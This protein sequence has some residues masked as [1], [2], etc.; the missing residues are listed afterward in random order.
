MCHK[1]AIK[2]RKT[3]TNLPKCENN[4]KNSMFF[5]DVVVHQ[6]SFLT[7]LF[8]LFG[9]P[10]T[11]GRVLYCIGFVSRSVHPSVY[12]SVRLDILELDHQFC[13]NFCIVVETYMKFCVAEPDFQVVFSPQKQG[14]WIK[15]GREIGS[16][17]FIEKFCH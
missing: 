12:L 1:G 5:M 10:T 14:K 16:L 2:E 17:N 11:A 15:N 4:I 3:C 7:I 6:F 13:L 8:F 9:P